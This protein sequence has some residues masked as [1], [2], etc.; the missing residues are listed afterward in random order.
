M[1][2]DSVPVRVEFAAGPS[3][4]V[5]CHSRELFQDFSWCPLGTKS[6]GRIGKQVWVDC[7]PNPK[8]NRVNMRKTMSVVVSGCS[9]E[10]LNFYKTQNKNGDLAVCVI[11]N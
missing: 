10:T 11:R 6:L 1:R 4:T 9:I 7:W 3:S 2:E 8:I 5:R